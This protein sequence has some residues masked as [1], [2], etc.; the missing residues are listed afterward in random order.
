MLLGKRQRPPIKRTTSMTEITFDLSTITESE[1]NGHQQ[2][3][4]FDPNNPFVGLDQ[5]FM[6]AASVSPRPRRTQR[7]NSAD[8]VETA[9]FL[10]ACFLCKR[11]LIPG[12]DIYMYRYKSS[13]KIFFF[14]LF[15]GFCVVSALFLID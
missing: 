8:F 1:I 3:Q 13:Q 2:P 5:R 6:T 14:F 4:P 10:K 7:R 12:R 15:E 11:R 9:P